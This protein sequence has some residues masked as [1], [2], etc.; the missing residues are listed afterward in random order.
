[1]I[2]IDT[3]GLIA[4]LFEDQRHHEAC[5][6]AL[7]EATPPRVV[8]PFVLA[9]VDY[10]ILKYG[11]VD[12]E[13][14]F[15]EEIGRRAYMLAPFDE[16]DVASARTIV[17]KYRNLKIGLADASIVELAARYN[18]RDLLTLDHRHFRAMRPFGRKAFR[19]LPEDG[20]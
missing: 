7:R 17:A 16:S 3:S 19:I 20:G 1:M 14:L 11:S 5:A 8:S 12:A 4:A 18:C 13:L 10:L 15:L 6:R 9:E 2:L